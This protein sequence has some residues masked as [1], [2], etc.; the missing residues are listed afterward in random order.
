[1]KNILFLSITTVMALALGAGCGLFGDDTEY[2]EGWAAVDSIRVLS[3]ESGHIDFLCYVSVANDCCT[4]GRHEI[5]VDQV[6]V[7]MRI[8]SKCRT[9]VCNAAIAYIE[10]E[11][12]FD[13]A[14]GQD[15]SFH[16]WRLG[17]ASLDTTIYVP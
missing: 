9:G 6:D 7:S 8:Y 10:V 5:D 3:V 17:E 13:C 11:L 4:Y 14:G 15:Y 2:R 12:P 1:M 16:F